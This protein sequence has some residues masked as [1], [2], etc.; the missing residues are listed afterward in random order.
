MG[1]K[2]KIRLVGAPPGSGKSAVKAALAEQ[3]G[4]TW[5]VLEHEQVFTPEQR[6]KTAE[7]A[8]VELN[9]KEFALGANLPGQMAF[10]A[11]LRTIADTGINVVGM[12]PFENVFSEVGGMPLWRKM[13]T[14]DFG[15]YDLNLVYFLV[16]PSFDS[17]WMLDSDDQTGVILDDGKDNPALTDVVEEEIQRRLRSR[18]TKSPYQ[19]KLGVADYYRRRVGSVLRSRGS[20]GLPIVYYP[21]QMSPLELAQELAQAVV[22]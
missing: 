12:G 9:S 2:G 5:L 4:S 20:F 3:L 19:E 18:I 14:E 21:C 7:P 16:T 17:I 11:L 1:K 15:S 6:V 8:G 22:R 13:K 10:Q